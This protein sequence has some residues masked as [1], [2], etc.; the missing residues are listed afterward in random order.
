MCLEHDNSRGDSQFLVTETRKEN[1][2]SA[3]ALRNA[4]IKIHMMKTQ[5]KH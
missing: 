3:T 5:V 2:M 1:D 4:D